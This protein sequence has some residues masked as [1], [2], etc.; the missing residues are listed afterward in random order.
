MKTLKQYIAFVLLAF[1]FVGLLNYFAY[2]K[3]GIGC[4]PDPPPVVVVDDW[5]RPLA[6]SGY[7]PATI[8]KPDFIHDDKFPESVEST[9][10][11]SGTV[12]DSVAVEVSVVTTPD[13]V[14]WIKAV[15][16]GETVKWSKVQYWNEPKPVQSQD[17]SLILAGEWVD[18]I[19]VGFGVAWEPLTV[20]GAKIGLQ[21]VCDINRDILASPDWLSV[22]G[23]ISKQFGSFSPG[24]SCGYRIGQGQGLAVGISAGIGISL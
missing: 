24:L 11:A 23:R 22:S 16:G 1:F 2:K 3:F 8:E 5:T 13:D 4:Q 20:R 18:G 19:D 14:T 15:Y 12:A 7:K 17:W 9:L 10:Y 6:E 21:A